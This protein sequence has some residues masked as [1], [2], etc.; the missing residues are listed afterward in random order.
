MAAGNAVWEILMWRQPPLSA[1]RSSEARR[2]LSSSGRLEYYPQQ[3]RVKLAL[4]AWYAFP[5]C[6]LFVAVQGVH[7]Q[8]ESPVSNRAVSCETFLGYYMQTT[9]RSIS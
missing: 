6:A 4:A 2:F 1:V 3:P 7:P 9:I 8:I 5:L